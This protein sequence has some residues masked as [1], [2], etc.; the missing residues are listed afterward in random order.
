[1]NNIARIKKRNTFLFK[2]KYIYIYVYVC[3]ICVNMVIIENADILDIML[4]LDQNSSDYITVQSWK[5][6]IETWSLHELQI[7]IKDCK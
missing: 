4:L 1:M 3:H 6:T 5:C 2:F 7:F